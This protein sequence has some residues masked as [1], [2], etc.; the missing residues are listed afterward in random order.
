MALLVRDVLSRT[1]KR[2]GPML[3]FFCPVSFNISKQL[4]HELIRRRI[5]YVEKFHVSKARFT[6]IAWQ[7][8]ERQN[9]SKRQLRLLVCR[10]GLLQSQFLHASDDGLC[11]VKPAARDLKLF[12]EDNTKGSCWSIL[13]VGNY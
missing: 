9:T 10:V 6:I 3:D 12:A 11:I 5:V 1:D 2:D 8:R 4:L 7:Q 13:E